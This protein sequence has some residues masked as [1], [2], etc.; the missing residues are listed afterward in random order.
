MVVPLAQLRIYVVAQLRNEMPL[1]EKLNFD[2][3]VNAIF[4]MLAA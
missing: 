3:F 2:C 4:K 1:K